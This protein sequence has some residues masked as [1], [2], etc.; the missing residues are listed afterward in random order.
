MTF[1]D[2]HAC[3]RSSCCEKMN[4]I[5]ESSNIHLNTDTSVFHFI[6]HREGNRAHQSCVLS[7][8]IFC[9]LHFTVDI[10]I[11]FWITYFQWA[12]IGRYLVIVCTLPLAIRF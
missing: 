2:F 9:S 7:S 4:I 3:I 6:F 5:F 11:I 12:I 10:L 1:E 8:I